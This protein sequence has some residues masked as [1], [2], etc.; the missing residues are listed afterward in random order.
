MSPARE[1]ELAKQEE[2]AQYQ[3]HQLVRQRQLEARTAA[4]SPAERREARIVDWIRGGNPWAEQGVVP[5]SEAQGRRE[6]VSAS[7]HG[8]PS[9]AAL[10][11]SGIA[12]GRLQ[13]SDQ[14]I[15]RRACG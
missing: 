2:A 4:L 10:S 11:A 3:Q 5:M 14:R 7:A 8:H 15:A 1:Y 6:Y 12:A 9:R 13:R